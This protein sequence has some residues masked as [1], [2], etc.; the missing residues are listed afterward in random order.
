VVEARKIKA[1]KMSSI[2]LFAKIYETNAY[3]VVAII[4]SLGNI[5]FLT[6]IL[7]FIVWFESFS[8]N[9]NRTLLNHLT[10]MIW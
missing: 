2:G 9:K 8:P 3:Q 7:A 1:V 6:P 5:L 10:S 4:S